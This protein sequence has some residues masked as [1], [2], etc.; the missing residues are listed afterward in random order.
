MPDLA[1]D[2]AFRE[3]IDLF[4]HQQ[5]FECHEVLED[6]WRPLPEGSEKLFLQGL[7]QIAVD[8]SLAKR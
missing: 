4:N 6:L 1:E 2:P 3:A 7:I 5:F 8:S